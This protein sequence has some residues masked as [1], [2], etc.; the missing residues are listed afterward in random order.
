MKKLE[1]VTKNKVN[2]YITK[3]KQNEVIQPTETK[4]YNKPMMTAE[5]IIAANQNSR[6][7]TIKP[8]TEK[9]G[10]QSI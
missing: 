1:Y 3:P 5:Q 7:I 10:L 2:N 6:P 4:T 8:M 9:N